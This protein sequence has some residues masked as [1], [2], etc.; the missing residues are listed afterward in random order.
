MRS[1]ITSGIDRL[2]RWA[3]R[4]SRSAVPAPAGSGPTRSDLLAT[5]SVAAVTLVVP[6]LLRSAPAQASSTSCFDQCDTRAAVAMLDGDAGCDRAAGEL[7]S[8]L[9]DPKSKFHFLDAAFVQE[10]Y[11]VICYQ[12]V[13][14]RALAQK[15]ACKAACLRGGTGATVTKSSRP[16]IAPPPP[17]PP[18]NCPE[19]TFFCSVGPGGGDICCVTGYACCSCGVCCVP[20]VKCAC[21]GG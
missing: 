17:P 1:E 12:G 11:K 14:A 21:C 15:V 9:L 4:R 16:P 3:A 8:K 13:I 18:P 5:A 10:Q 2:A 20:A 19:G 6:R 7:T